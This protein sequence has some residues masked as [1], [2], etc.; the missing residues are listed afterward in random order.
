MKITRNA[1]I[2]W[3]VELKFTWAKHCDLFVLG[4]ANA[5]NDDGANS[6]NIIF[7]LKHTKSYIPVVILTSKDNQNLS[8]FLSKE[9]ERSV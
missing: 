4:A 1:I 3:K 8:K 2:N 7:I 5:D 9:F 6:K